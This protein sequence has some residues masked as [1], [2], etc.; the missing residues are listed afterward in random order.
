M[1][2]NEFSPLSVWNQE[3]K[4]GF[5]QQVFIMYHG[6]RNADTARSILLKGFASS[7][8]H[9]Q[10]LGNGIYV[11][12]SLAKCKAYGD[13]T[14][15]LLVYPGSVCTVKYQGHPLQKKWHSQCGSAYVPANCGMVPS[16]LPVS[17]VQGIISAY[18]NIHIYF[19]RKTVSSPRTRLKFLECVVGTKSW[20][21]TQRRVREIFV[22]GKQ[23]FL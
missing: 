9:S 2:S 13:I 21:I 16:G 17:L 8:G 23:S 18:V 19:N 15:K 1:S 4:S 11:S 6:T 3:T 10:M 5:R 14:F 12:A 22:M 7:T 20:I